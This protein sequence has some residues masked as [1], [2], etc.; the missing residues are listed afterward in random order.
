MKN[1]DDVQLVEAHKHGNR[2]AFNELV[3]R[4]QERIYWVVRRLVNSH[5]DSLDIAQDVFIRA[6]QNLEGFRGDAQFFTWIYK[7]AVNLSLNHIRK[8][9]I[10]NLLHVDDFL[11]IIAD[12]EFRPDI[13]LEKEQFSDILQKAIATLPTKQKAVFLMRYFDE[14][15]YDEIAK[16]LNRTTGALKANYFHAVRKIED[17]IK[18]EM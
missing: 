17:F 7:I 12:N 15:P 1:Y 2:E 11:E 13:P 9:K 4:Y 8:R 5:D 18:H 10:R 14:M 3:R 6:F 16:V